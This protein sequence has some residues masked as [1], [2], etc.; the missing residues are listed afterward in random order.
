MR[1]PENRIVS[2]SPWWGSAVSSQKNAS[3]SSRDALVSGEAIWSPRKDGTP[4][5]GPG[6][7]TAGAPG[8]LG[9]G[10]QIQ[11]G[12]EH[13]DPAG[14]ELLSAPGG[15]EAG[16]DSPASSPPR[17]WGTRAHP[18]EL[19]SLTVWGPSPHARSEPS[20][21]MISSP[22]C[23]GTQRSN[24]SASRPSEEKA[25]SHCDSGRPPS[26][27]RPRSS[28]P[29]ALEADRF[30]REE[31]LGRLGRVVDRAAGQLLQSAEAVRAVLTAD[32]MLIVRERTQWAFG[33]PT[34]AGG[35]GEPSEPTA[36]GVYAAI[37]ATG[38]RLFGTPS[39]AGR[40]F[41]VIGLSQVGARLS[42]AGATLTVTD[43]DPARQVMAREW[44]ATWVETDVAP[45]NCRGFRDIRARPHCPDRAPKPFRPGPGRPPGS[46][47][48]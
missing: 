22:G 5:I 46:K 31:Q 21:R 43:I 6:R 38:T 16:S 47:H 33:L 8:I 2:G 34:E 24:C 44:G 25:P 42:A 40:R 37:E 19:V 27:R 39:P 1:A 35:S 14:A 23:S 45:T 4:I 3:G 32:D 29:V 10:Q 11:R 9:L 7:T 12:R 26:R 36:P 20:R 13:Q 17:E 48:R 28:N 41:T 15:R 30:R 18:T